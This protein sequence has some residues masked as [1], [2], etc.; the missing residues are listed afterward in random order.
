M[1][2]LQLR[3]LGGFEARLAT[4]EGIELRSQRAQAILAYLAVQPG[5]V[6]S[7]D[8]LADLLWSDRDETHA[9]SSLRQAL[10]ALRKALDAA[11][12]QPLAT[13]RTSVTID[14]AAVDVDVLAFEDLVAGGSPADLERALEFSNGEFLAGLGVRAP[15][16]EEWLLRERDRLRG[17]MI[18]ALGKVLAEKA[19]NGSVDEALGLAQRLLALDLAHEPAHRAI[20]RLYA[21]IGQRDAALR[22]Y[23]ICREVLARELDVA[24]EPE[25]EV[26]FER[27]HNG[28]VSAGR[29]DGDPGTTTA[30]GTSLTTRQE[31]PEATEPVIEER[32]SVGQQS[33]R[34]SWAAIGAALVVLV[35][36]GLVVWQQPWETREEPA[37]VANMAFPLPDRPSIAILPFANLS[38][39]PQQD[40]FVDGMTEDLIT[41]LAKLKGLFVMARNTVFT[42]KNKPVTVKQVAEELGVRYVLEGSMR[43]AGDQVRINAQLVDA[44]TGFHLWADRYDGTLENIFAL[45][46]TISQKIVSALAVQLSP[47]EESHNAR[48]ETD[49]PE[50]YDAFLRGWGLARTYSDETQAEAIPY[51]RKAVELDS[52]YGRAYAALAEVYR[53]IFATGRQKTFGLTQKEIMDL[54]A[55][56]L[57]QALK[58]PTPLAYSVA[59]SVHYMRGEYEESIAAAEHAIALGAQDPWS[60]HALAKALL[61]AGRPAEA[62]ENIDKAARLDPLDPAGFVWR[63]GQVLYHLG[64]FE[65]SATQFSISLDA[66]DSITDTHMFLAANY[67]Q[68]ARPEDAKAAIQQI[69]TMEKDEGWSYSVLSVDSWSYKLEENRQQFREGLRKAGLDEIPWGYD[70]NS[71]NMI[72]GDDLR[73]LYFGRTLKGTD[74]QSGKERTIF[75]SEDGKATSRIGDLVDIGRL[76]GWHDEKLCIRWEGEGRVCVVTFRNPEGTAEQFNEYDYVYFGGVIPFSPI[77]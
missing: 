70:V 24:P 13:D 16:F 39:D 7:R 50:A 61:Y 56:Y 46:D 4:G 58:N 53:S 15:V 65:D 36:G 60:Y 63:R 52:N 18:G 45:Q 54:A 55:R 28:Q 64:R 75:I 68:L 20:M 37:S 34:W 14:P 38:D 9:R 62:L 57:D 48:I 40:Y 77:D 31:W 6:Q 8:A 22:Q 21:E 42:Y 66:G 71:P 26:L 19:E 17:L 23:Q 2:L 72:R 41:D 59:T 27:I 11:E 33:R 67:G 47:D 3:L 35:G 43:R 76:D 12:P 25:T 1:G 73:S 51:L 30:Q 74:A 10:T 49:N 44:V 69:R 29:I 32:R 5:R